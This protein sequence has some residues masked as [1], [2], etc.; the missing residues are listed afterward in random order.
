[1]IVKKQKTKTLTVRPNGRSADA[2][3]PNHLNMCG[4]GCLY[5]YCKRFERFRKKGYIN[6]NRDE[7][8]SSVNDWVEQQPFPKTPNQVHP[9]LY[10]I[11]IG[12]A[13]DIARHWKD[14]D[15]P[16]VLEWYRNHPK[17]FATFATK[18]VNNQLLKYPGNRIR[19]SLMPQELSDVLEPGT[20]PIRTRIKAIDR[21]ID[22]GWEVHINLSPVVYKKGALDFYRKLFE[23]IAKCKHV[24]KL[25]S[26]VIFATHHEGLHKYNLEQGFTEAENLLW[27]PDIQELKNSQYQNNV[28]R[29]EKNVKKKLINKFKKVYNE[30][31]PEVNIRYIF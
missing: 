10:G 2:T 31:I 7:I 4:A 5:C 14:Y 20:S 28:L 24:D 17:C 21:F 18:F 15:W 19:F 25:Q 8:L 30:Y 22:A 27:K 26:E 13:T 29:Y 9:T 3:A 6:T 16:Y 23:E 11:D 1:M 12:N